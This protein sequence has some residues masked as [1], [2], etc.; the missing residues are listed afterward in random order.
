MKQLKPILKEISFYVF[1]LLS[2]ATI[3]DSSLFA[4]NTTIDWDLNTRKFVT[5][6]VYARV[7]K[8][9][10]GELIMAY[11]DGPDVFIR[12]SGNNGTNWGNPV[13][14]AHN[15][16]YNN[17]NAEVSQLANDW[18]IFSWNGRP[19]TD[20]S[21]PYTIKTKISRDWGNTWG[22][23]RTPYSADVTFNNGAWE[24]VTLQIPSG[25]VQ[26]YFANENPYRNSNEQEITIM[27]SYDNGLSWG[28]AK[29]VSFRGGFRDGMPVP[30]YLKNNKG[31]AFCIEDNGINGTFKPVIIWSSTGD[32]WNQSAISGNSPSRWH[33]LRSDFQ[34]ASN[35]YGGAPYI[36]QLPSGE[37]VLSIQS[38]EGRAGESN[39]MMQVYVGDD[40]AR[41]F[42][43]RSVP[44]TN[45]PSNGSGLW[46]SL[47]V[48][49]DNTVMAVSSLTGAGSNGIWTIIG[50]VV[51]TAPVSSGQVYRLVSRNSNQVLDVNACSTANG[52]NVQQWPWLGGNCQRW[53]I[54]ATDNGYYRL[55][56]VQSNQ[57][58]EVNACSTTNGANVQQWP[59]NGGYCQQW[60][61]EPFDGHFRL[62]ARHSGQAL[63]VNAC[64]T[65]N[66][67]N[68]QQWPWNGATCQQWRIEAVAATQRI[69]VEESGVE[70]EKVKFYPNPAGGQVTV[71]W[72]DLT[73]KSVDILL[74]DTNGKVIYKCWVAKGA[75]KI[76]NTSDLR[77]GIYFITIENDQ[78][79]IRKKLLVSR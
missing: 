26:L 1:L 55:I 35:V 21:I 47:T 37:T 50:R 48:I 40:N 7:K 57:A 67:A 25:E 3:P 73:T 78:I 49:D 75:Q 58:L 11:S 64:S 79:Q 29:A 42:C 51:R 28:G 27:R 30:V 2:L 38:S 72:E 9:R 68:V 10:N 23:E 34:L 74:T 6:G 17:T 13:L 22:D 53:R 20:G 8:L 4:Q 24:P 69:S 16:G 45:V 70:N 62:M 31:I 19:L 36:V 65:A 32:N 56:S 54:E 15:N 71:E 61:I 52:A 41:N 60:K 59:W 39:A 46:N 66:G 14:V 18:L 63:D 33:A 77:D 12:K 43:S 5:S 44:F 76:L